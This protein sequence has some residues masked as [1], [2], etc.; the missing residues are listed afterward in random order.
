MATPGGGGG[1]PPTVTILRL[2]PVDMGL[3]TDG[4]ELKEE[5]RTFTRGA[6][7]D[8]GGPMSTSMLSIL[9]TVPICTH[10]LTLL[11]HL[12]A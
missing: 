12:V 9:N 4:A 7:G 8:G 3:G 11:V 2:C 6:R 5:D 10:S 1:N